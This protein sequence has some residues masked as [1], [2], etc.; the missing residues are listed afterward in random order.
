MELGHVGHTIDVLSIDCEGCEWTSYRDI[1][2]SSD[3]V[4]TQI[5]MELHGAPYVI[6]DFFLEMKRHSYVVFHKESNT[7]EQGGG[8]I[9]SYSFIRLAPAFFEA[10]AL[11]VAML[12]DEEEKGI[13][14]VQ[15][16]LPRRI[17]YSG[18]GHQQRRPKHAL[19]H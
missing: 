5:L 19:E 18:E 14:V 8:Q 10:A 11:A 3:S 15:H 16:Q 12:E 9:C 13:H 17:Q 7:V 2:E 6:N 1:L 4:I